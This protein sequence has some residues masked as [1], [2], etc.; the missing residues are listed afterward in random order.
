[1]T[2]AT[3]A[4]ADLAYV[5]ESTWGTTPG[6][7]SMK[8]LRLTSES[9]R[10]KID[11]L[12]SKEIRS[13]RMIAALTQGNLDV[14]G[15][16]NFEFSHTSFDEILEA[17]LFGDWEDISKT[18]AT[19]A[20][21]SGTPATITDSGNG[22]VTAGFKVGNLIKVSGS[23]SNDGYYTL[24][25]VTAGTLT[26]ATGETLTDESAGASVTITSS[27]L[28]AGTT[29]KSFTLEKRFTDIDQYMVFTGCMVNGMNL[30]I[31]PGEIVTGGF[32]IFGKSHSASG[33]S[34]GTPTDVAS[35]TPFNSFNGTLYEGGST[36]AIVT[37]LEIRLANNIAGRWAIGSNKDKAA[38]FPGRSNCAGT[39]SAFF[40][41]L[42]LYN[43]F[44]NGTPS[45]LKVILND[46][47][48]R[49]AIIIPN[50]KYSGEGTPVI[51]GENDLVLNL[52]FQ[53]LRDSAEETSLKISRY[54][55]V[56]I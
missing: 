20:F 5:M 50:I 46:G 16:I 34:L 37:S 19:I 28:K 44:L 14:A 45:S 55:P 9:V 25:G 35:T 31:T 6:S 32:D 21:V 13:D 40:Q 4:Y 48:N 41:D 23:T 42:T 38:K 49:T 12:T 33:T 18:A 51:N 2:Y 15:S 36:I 30:R 8:R 11:G 22:F 43:K 53:A 27:E 7:P 39:L 24:A 47:T 1:M 52:N 3:G 29:D 17:A 26:L 54:V 10:T 56:Q